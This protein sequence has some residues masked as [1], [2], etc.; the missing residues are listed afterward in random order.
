MGPHPPHAGMEMVEDEEKNW[1]DPS[2]TWQSSLREAA[3]RATLI[4][5]L[6]TE[7]RMMKSPLT[8]GVRKGR[9]REEREEWRAWCSRE[10]EGKRDGEEGGRERDG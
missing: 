4:R 10:T 9:E 1:H 6:A 7:P 8:L 3:L 2:L 5:D